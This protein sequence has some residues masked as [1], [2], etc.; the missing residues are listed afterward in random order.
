MRGY[1]NLFPD[2][3]LSGVPIQ[4]LESLSIQHAQTTHQNFDTERFEEPLSMNLH[5]FSASVASSISDFGTEP[6]IVQSL[7]AT[8]VR[9]SAANEVLVERHATQMT[10]SI[11]IELEKECLGGIRTR[12]DGVFLLQVTN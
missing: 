9:R 10:E 6:E 12:K 2:S 4:V 5:V 1:Y 8:R 3:L 11:C 7:S